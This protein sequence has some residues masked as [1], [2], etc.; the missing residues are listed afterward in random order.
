[1]VGRLALGPNEVD[2]TPGKPFSVSPSVLPRRSTSA[3][4]VSTDTGEAISVLPSGLPVT[5]TLSS[6]AGATVCA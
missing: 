4:P 5:T 3:S 6:V 1:M 2:D